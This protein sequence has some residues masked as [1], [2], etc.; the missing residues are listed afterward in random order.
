[1]NVCKITCFF[2]NFLVEVPINRI[3][4]S[5]QNPSKIL[6]LKLS[7][8]SFSLLSLTANVFA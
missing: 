7:S 6:C 5:I 2:F 1:M 4:R 8:E 3:R